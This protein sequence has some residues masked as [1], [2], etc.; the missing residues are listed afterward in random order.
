[1][2]I[3]TSDDVKKMNKKRI[4]KFMPKGYGKYIDKITNEKLAKGVIEHDPLQS[5]VTEND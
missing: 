1:M 2:R 3:Y 5:E 4:I